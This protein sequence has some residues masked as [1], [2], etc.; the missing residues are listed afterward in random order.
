MG[1]L[2]DSQ[3]KGPRASSPSGHR[4]RQRR[5]AYGHCF[6]IGEPVGGAVGLPGVGQPGAACAGLVLLHPSIVTTAGTATS[7]AHL[8]A[9]R[10]A[11]DTKLDLGLFDRFVASADPGP[12]PGATLE[13]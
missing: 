4:Q 13:R 5:L 3:R 8:R 9:V 1:L 11:L 7:E 10:S 6:G 12:T 2:S